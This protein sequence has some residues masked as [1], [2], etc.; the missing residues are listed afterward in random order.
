[1]RGGKSSFKDTFTP[2]NDDGPW[3][4]QER[5]IETEAQGDTPAG[6]QTFRFEGLEAL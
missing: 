2:L 6:C 1:L 4:L 5:V 3:V